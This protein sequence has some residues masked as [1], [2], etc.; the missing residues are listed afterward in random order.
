MKNMKLG[1]KIALGFGILIV[2]AGILG[3][4]GVVQMGTVERQT[5]KLAKEYVPE[6]E[7]AVDLRGAANRVMYDMRGYAFTEDSKFHDSAQKELQAVDNALEKGRRLEM[8]SKNLKALKEQLE[9]AT[10][11]RGRVQGSGQT[12]R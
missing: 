7:M 8:K 3:G 6:V 5:A 2:I 11:S 12:V 4:V 9:V 1:A 10:R